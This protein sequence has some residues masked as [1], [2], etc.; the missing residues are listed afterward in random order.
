[1]NKTTLLK[2]IV[3]ALIALSL[4]AC[5]TFKSREL[6]TKKSFLTGLKTFDPSTTD[7]QA[8]EGTLSPI[9]VGMLPIEGGSFT[10][11]QE[12]EF[13]TAPH[14]NERRT[15]TVSSFYMDKYEVTNVGWREYVDWNKFVFGNTKP[16]LVKALLP[17]TTVWRTELAYNDPYVEH[18]YSHPAYSF[19]PVVGVSWEQAMAYCQWRTDRV[20]EN[21]L[22]TK[23][24]MELPP[25]DKLRSNTYMTE[26]EIDNF[27]LNNSAH[28]E[29]AAYT[30]Q[31]V[32]VPVAI[33][34]KYGYNGDT[35]STETVTMY[36]LPYEWIR[37]Q[38]VFNTEK[39]YKDARYNPSPGKA[40]RK[41]AQGFPR[42]VNSSDGVLVLGY[43][44]PTEA[45]WEYAA[46]APIAGKEGF[47]QEGKI[48][49]WSGFHPRDLSTYNKGKMLANFVR[50]KGDMMGVAGDHND[51]YVLTAPVDA[52]M[53][54]DFGLYNMAGNVNEWV[55]DVYRETTF[56]EVSEYNPYR[57]NVYSKMKEDAN[58]NP[59]MNEYGCLAIEYKVED[60]KRNYRDGDMGSLFDT[61]YPLDTVGLTLEQKANVKYD[62]SDILAPR[63]NNRSRV[64]KGGSWNDRIYWLNPTTRRYMDQG[65]SSSTIGFRCAMSIVGKQL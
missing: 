64:Y 22:V 33:A 35:T 5:E 24:L 21:I 45:E 59:V 26:E 48:Y 55:M 52:Y 18:Y 60:D 15:L 53:P 47:P 31:A 4:S 6:N 2:T 8:F 1:M 65:Q 17:D 46:F 42:K 34:Q 51:E 39:Y 13:I 11:G 63:I 16:E 29:Y 37:D 44:L 61:D 58:G 28:P 10:I 50:G 20:N 43:R 23:K 36:Q 40:T 12:D 56:E 41:D 19:Y 54:N 7:F 49:P 27:L 57:G 9:P 32:E 14:N 38:F 25:Y 30:K 62:P 3:F